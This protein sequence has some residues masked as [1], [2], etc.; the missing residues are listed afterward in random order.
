MDGVEQE[1][2]YW[3]IKIPTNVMWTAAHGPGQAVLCRAE[4]MRKTETKVL[5]GALFTSTRQ[6][7]SVAWSRHVCLALTLLQNDNFCFILQPCPGPEPHPPLK[8]YCN[9]HLASFPAAG[10]TCPRFMQLTLTWVVF[11]TISVVPHC[12]VWLYTHMCMY[13]LYWYT[14]YLTLSY[15]TCEYGI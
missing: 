12:L 6:S 5:K 13:Y 9:S 8:D 3:L 2:V 11:L 4:R 7:Q 15:L 1:V 10:L 14:W